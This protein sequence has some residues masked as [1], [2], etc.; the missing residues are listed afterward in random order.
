MLFSSSFLTIIDVLTFN[1]KCLAL[2]FLFLCYRHSL[3]YLYKIVILALM[4]LNFQVLPIIVWT[5]IPK[6][7]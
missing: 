1:L 7:K 2:H 6:W 5:H 3:S 4:L